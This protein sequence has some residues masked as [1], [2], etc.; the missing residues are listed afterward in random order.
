MSVQ[1]PLQLFVSKFQP[2]VIT[3]CFSGLLSTSLDCSCSYSARALLLHI[4]K[5]DSAIA[6]LQSTG[7]WCP[8]LACPSPPNS[9]WGFDFDNGYVDR[10][11]WLGSFLS[12][13]KFFHGRPTRQ[14]NALDNWPWWVYMTQRPKCFPLFTRLSSPRIDHSFP[15]LRCLLLSSYL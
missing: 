9:I 1:C 7:T 12:S 5:S 8:R 3:T 4:N 11:S 15:L 6:S 10:T 13:L 14:S 2:H